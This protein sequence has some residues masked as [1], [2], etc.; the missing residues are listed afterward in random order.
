MGLA[1][2]RVT[3]GKVGPEIIE[4]VPVTCAPSE[5]G[6]D[7]QCER[8][9]ANTGEVLTEQV[10]GPRVIAGGR[11][12]HHL[13]VMTFPVH[14][15]TADDA[16][17]R[18]GESVEIGDCEPER[19]IDRD[20]VTERSHCAGSVRGL[21]CLAIVSSR[22]AAC[23]DRPTV[24]LDR[25]TSSRGRLDAAGVESFQVAVHAPQGAPVT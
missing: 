18:F 24:I 10:G 12:A 11:R 9:A 17:R 25:G 2:S 5:L 19:R 1:A 4:P 23:R 14:L 8:I 20:R 21:L 13:D 22:L 16:R 15:A 7:A 3:T 6:D